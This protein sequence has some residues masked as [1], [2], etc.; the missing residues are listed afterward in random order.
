MDRCSDRFI[1]FTSE[2]ES[3]KTEEVRFHTSITSQE[4]KEL[5]R[6]AAE[7][8]PY[9]ILKLLTSDGQM[10]NIT[11]SLPSNSVD[12]PHQ[13][14][15]VAINCKGMVLNGMEIDLS[16]FEERV[17]R[18]EKQLIEQCHDLPPAVHKLK[19]SV[20]DFRDKLEKSEH[21]SWLG[22]GKV[23]L[24]E[25]NPH[26]RGGRVENH[27]GKTTPVHPTEIRTSISPTSAVELNMTSAL[28]KYATEAGFWNVFVSVTQL[29]TVDFHV[30]SPG[31]IL[32]LG[33]EDGISMCVTCVWW[34][35]QTTLVL[36]S[37][38][39]LE[40]SLSEEVRRCLRQPSFDCCQW[41][42]EE[43]LVLLQ[44]MYLDLDF[45][46]K[47]NIDLR[48]LRNFLFEVYTNY[49]EIPFHNFKHCFCVAQMMYA[50]VWIVDLTSKIGD[51]ET[52]ILLTSCICHDLDH[53]GYNNIYQIN[54]KTELAL[55]YN[56][57]SPLENH[58]CS[59]AFRILENPEWN[60]FQSL[61]GETFRQVREGIIRC[62]LATDMARH[63]EILA[64]FKDVTPEFDFNNK[65]HTNLLS[66]IL[67]KVADISNE[68]RPMDV[69]E[70]W[71]DKLLQ[72]FFKQSDAEKLE[73]LPVTPFMDRDKI[74][75]P[76]S[77]CSF[78]GFVLLPLFEALGDLFT[79]LQGVIV[80]P[81]RDALDYYRRL[82]DAA[83]DER[84]H[85]K[86]V[87]EA[88]LGSS[89]S[90]ITS[91]DS[92]QG[93]IAKSVSTHSVKSRRSLSNFLVRARSRSVDDEDVTPE[94]VE[95]MLEQ[96]EED[97]DQTVTEVEVSEKTL[98]FKISTEGNIT[99]GKSYPGSRKGSKDKSQLHD[100]TYSE[101]AK[102]I[103]DRDKEMNR[104]DSP[105]KVFS[106]VSST[107]P[108]SSHDSFLMG[109]H[110]EAVISQKTFQ[111][112]KCN[113]MID[114]SKSSKET[115]E[116]SGIDISDHGNSP[117]TS[118]FTSNSQSGNDHKAM[119]L[120]KV[121]K[122]QRHSQRRWRAFLGGKSS[123]TTLKFE[124][125]QSDCLTNEQ[126][127]P[128]E[129]HCGHERSGY[130]VHK[131]QMSTHKAMSSTRQKPPLTGSLDSVLQDKT[132]TGGSD[133]VRERRM[134]TAILGT[135]LVVNYESLAACQLLQ[136]IRNTNQVLK[137][138]KDFGKGSQ[139]H[140]LSI[141]NHLV[142]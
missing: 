26:L 107:S 104:S 15:I 40:V 133:I 115:K 28:A 99:G 114:D 29:F 42:D 106:R 39:D 103:K 50:I 45:L 51:L 81:V 2:T 128:K 120:P 49:N 93:S 34:R 74:T 95:E 54:A 113:I 38:M 4:L 22:I 79:E 87:V 61:K 91:G 63:N 126:K 11:P 13:L 78:I 21:L 10:L 27:L 47:F 16:S 138:P 30:G 127:Y 116:E 60:I 75:K 130:A 23:E 105:M 8:G 125:Q 19:K 72:E 88:A 48:V 108:V 65:I 52:M 89:D 33:C 36:G 70:P 6:S 118:Y 37:V 69:A 132:S 41:E 20:D 136:N 111:D 1:F 84:L 24:E 92:N 46:T 109:H 43:I 3:R 139:I 94:G 68:A 122:S 142:L 55:R 101:L 119:T 57:I 77:Q 9:D 141:L 80:Q 35:Q 97:T 121:K 18:L 12:S 44:Q 123:Q 59:V 71:L 31:L 32:L 64:Q 82:N 66:M 129:E 85:R 83:K 56:D 110:E 58:H 112:D 117:S 135:T 96:D 25:V 98:K 73:G 100:Y 131:K 102:A 86:S 17:T 7:A 76:S 137:F 134:D 53:P 140:G 14:K 5:F 62:I 124:L 90:V 67:I